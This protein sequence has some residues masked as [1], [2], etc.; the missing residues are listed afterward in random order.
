M[1]L[2]MGLLWGTALAAIPIVVHL[3]HR[4][5]T[6]PVEWGAMQFLTQTPVRMRRRKWIDNWLLLLVRMAM[7]ALLAIVLARPLMRTGAAKAS[8]PMDV[9]VVFDHSLSTG[10]RAGGAAN[11]G[12]Q[13]L[14]EQSLGV[15]EQVRD[16]LPAGST[17]S[18][19]VAEHRPQVITPL[20]IST[21][22]DVARVLGQLRQLKPG[23]TD[24]SIPQAVQE[25]R[26][27]LIGAGKN[28]HKMIVIVSDDQRSGWSVDNPT[29]WRAA[30]GDRN[31]GQDKDLSVFAVSVPAKDTGP[32]VVDISVSGLSVQ[33]GMLA[34]N[35]P[36]QISFTL[37][38]QGP[39]AAQSF[40]VDVT[41]DGRPLTTQM[42][43]ALKA[44]D[45]QTISL[46]HVFTQAGS[47]QVRVTAQ[48]VDTLDAD[49]T[50]VT[51]ATVVP[52]VNVLIIDGQLTGAGARGYRGAEFLYG[53]FEAA[54]SV[55]PKVIGLADV[56]A[57]NLEPY[58][59]VILNDVPNL[60]PEMLARL[61]EHVQRG[62]GAWIILGPRTDA[63]W[64]NETLAK[65]PL[66][67]GRLKERTVAR[68]SPGVIDIKNPDNPAIAML[69]LAERNTFAGTTVSA[70]WEIED[71]GADEATVLEVT[72]DGMSHPL[73]L[74]HAVGGV[75]G[76]GR[77][78]DARG[79]PHQ[80]H[81]AAGD[82]LSP[83]GQR[84]RVPPR[85]RHEPRERFS[86]APGAGDPLDQPARREH[87]HRQGAAARWRRGPGQGE[88]A[89]RPRPGDL[90]GNV[91]AGPLSSPVGSS[92]L[93][94]SH[95]LRRLDRPRRT[96]QP[97]G[98]ARRVGFAARIAL[99]QRP[100]HAGELCHRRQDFR[101]RGARHGHRPLVRPRR[102]GAAGPRDLPH[103]P[104]RRAA[105]RQRRPRAAG[106]PRMMRLAD[107]LAT[108]FFSSGQLDYDPAF[109]LWLMIPVFIAALMAVVL[110]SAAQMKVA[111]GRAVFVLA[112]LRV[113]AIGLLFV[114]LLRPFWRWMNTSHSS[115]TLWFVLDQSPSMATTD[116]QISAVEKLRWA[117]ALGYIP[118]RER[119]YRPELDTAA[120][121][122]LRSEFAYIS[123]YLT[124]TAG[125]TRDAETLEAV[126]KQLADYVEEL[127]A[128]VSQ[129][130]RAPSV[131]A[132]ALTPLDAAVRQS[133]ELAKAAA[134]LKPG[135]SLG[136][137]ASVA[138]LDAISN[139]FRTAVGL[140]ENH[141]NQVDAAFLAANS[142]S[143]TLDAGMARV[144]DMP[145]SDI[146]LQMITAAAKRAKTT[147]PELLKKFRVRIATFADGAAIGPSLDVMKPPEAFHAGLMTSGSSTDIATGLRLVAEQL[148]P[149][150]PAA[151]IIVSDG[152][153][154]VLR[155]EPE[156][157][158]RDLLN[159]KIPVHVHGLLIGSRQVTPDAAAEPPQ[160]RG[161]D[162]QGRHARHCRADPPRRPRRQKR[163]G[164]TAPQRRA[165]RCQDHP[166]HFRPAGNAAC[167]LHR[168]TT[169]VG[170]V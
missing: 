54:G 17:I 98:P 147:V 83:A 37:T 58:A 35:R 32:N 34:L 7:I 30:L 11:A 85:R 144:P 123:N 29:P 165:G 102:A 162:L 65:T 22:T 78:V 93:P 118:A 145:R 132:T 27:L 124:R 122:Y 68:T 59:A 90:C 121:M 82:Q 31:N 50:A 91:A 92:Q 161:M 55:R 42:I 137:I 97:R 46:P 146:A 81:A 77:A 127:E 95:L 38:N 73:V 111:P 70:W 61:V 136:D 28:A 2:M 120:V 6:T 104:R 63:K 117:D 133:Q 76:Q 99:H 23:L 75:G 134:R 160:S 158:A 36:C 88:P 72:A 142:G 89:R 149:E 44:H 96:R 112:L 25:A 163:D 101:D 69:T 62:N 3:M 108:G 4:Q 40:P 12:G 47:H 131:P 148:G 130:K 125:G 150:E 9:A 43:P 79:G 141:A 116:P 103:A 10:R 48:T 41:V 66:F 16:I 51:V 110:M 135:A 156:Q 60:P 166:R 57:E 100:R 139:N 21:A 109:S 5:K 169:R 119:T 1:F 52:Q 84:N 167:H 106:G 80:R 39:G 155:G 113:V 86:A 107:T 19:V 154:N 126:S 15:L 71:L 138:T 105:V 170:G 56:A 159:R 74:E 140:L 115:G 94:G 128:A 64:V 20:P 13:T 45:A 157:A 18:V 153:Q 33:P 164:G 151:V 67:S 87:P 26:Q 49:N 14:F 143:S 168:Q 53:A 152:R 8:V 114:L 129:I 24:A